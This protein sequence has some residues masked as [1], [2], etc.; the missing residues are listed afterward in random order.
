MDHEEHAGQD[1]CHHLDLLSSGIRADV[2]DLRVMRLAR[3]RAHV[4]V[5]EQ[6]LLDAT[7]ADAVHASPTDD[8]ELEA[9]P[10]YGIHNREAQG[11]DQGC[12][13]SSCDGSAARLP[14]RTDPRTPELCTTS[15]AVLVPL[16]SLGFLPLGYMRR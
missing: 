11:M 13:P 12:A 6:S 9:R 7:S 4:R 1:Y 5:R 3:D 10:H 8:C 16:V 2:A 15:A 14:V